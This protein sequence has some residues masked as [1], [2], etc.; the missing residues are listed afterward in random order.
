M[1]L[2]SPTNHFRHCVHMGHE[3]SA[4]LRQHDKHELAND[5]QTITEMLQ[6]AGRN[7]ED[8][9]IPIKEAIGKRESAEA[10]IDVAVR[11]FRLKLSARG[12]NATSK[13]PY[14]H[15]FHHGITYYI[16]NS[17]K[18]I[19]PRCAELLA[20]V[21]SELAEDDA[22]RVEITQAITTAQERFEMAVDDVNAART[23]AA[24]ARTHYLTTRKEWNTRM[25][26]VYAALLADLG[27]HEANR[28]FPKATK[29]RESVLEEN[30]VAVSAETA[31]QTAS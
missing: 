26:R 5:V 25:T 27:K 10:A 29:P 31:V 20:R 6:D 4:R 24:I 3:V 13:P 15:I 23:T 30:I 8:S 17:L 14:T 19:K 16:S 1:Y 12:L 11:D 7:M 9:K 21:E 2:P 22:L 18:T 28:F